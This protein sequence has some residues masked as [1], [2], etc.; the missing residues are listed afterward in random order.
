MNTP[1]RQAREQQ[2]RL[3]HTQARERRNKI[4]ELVGC[5]QM[6]PDEANR[7]ASEESLRPF[8][9]SPD[10]AEFMVSAMVSWSIEMAMAW[11]IWRNTERVLQFHDPF[12][13][14][15]TYWKP[16]LRGGEVAGF[17]IDV[18]GPANLSNLSSR[19]MFIYDNTVLMDF[20]SAENVLWQGLE[21]GRLTARAIDTDSLRI[22]QIP[23]Y[24]WSYLI[25]AN[26]D[27]STEL[28]VEA[29]GKTLYRDIKLDR[30]AVVQIWPETNSTPSVNA[31]V[32]GPIA[33]STTRVR[34][35]KQLLVKRALNT[36]FPDG[37]YPDASEMTN[38]VLIERVGKVMME[39]KEMNSSLEGPPSNDTILR[40][41]GRKQSKSG[42]F[43]TA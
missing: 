15:V 27:S 21:D 33:A 10:P 34:R 30:A 4:I 18:H 22:K 5:G 16:I 19:S 36:L 37:K 39:Q 8:V 23:N 6:H 17:E 14:K 29:F 11:I 31:P 43:G 1:A 41:V 25:V 9:S 2:R 32:E 28:R 13:S 35:T 26:R 40:A 20:R 38:A 12:R 3:K 7:I 24:E 42:S